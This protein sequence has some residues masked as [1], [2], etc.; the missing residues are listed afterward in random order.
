M[1]FCTCIIS[2]PRVGLQFPCMLSMHTHS[3]YKGLISIYF[4]IYNIYYIIILQNIQDHEFQVESE[5]KISIGLSRVASATTRETFKSTRRVCLAVWQIHSVD[6]NARILSS[7]IRFLSTFWESLEATHGNLAWILSR[8]I[9]ASSSSLAI[10][11]R[12]LARDYF[13]CCALL[14]LSG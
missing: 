11:G 14:V 12:F 5:A 3:R 2:K 7:H 9:T 4:G 1:V 10:I 6:D 13:C 8:F